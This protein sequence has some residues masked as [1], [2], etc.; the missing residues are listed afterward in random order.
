MKFVVASLV[1]FCGCV[2]AAAVMASGSLDESV[3]RARIRTERTDAE[4]AYV[5]REH[6][7]RQRFA[8]NR[9]LDEARRDRRRTLDSLRHQEGILD[10]VQ[11]KQRAAERMAA[12]RSKIAAEDSKRRE[13]A[14]REHHK[15]ATAGP[16]PAKPSLTESTPE[17]LIASE[18]PGA[19]PLSRETAEERARRA[20]DYEKRQA[21]ARAHRETVERRNAERA[22][23]GKPA[24]KA[25]PAPPSASAP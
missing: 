22:R 8:V 15:Q 17:N 2:A 6:E 3:E 24:A 9:C 16:L 14:A 23:S 11:R 10:E 4:A 7:C 13:P 25:L 21:A 20:A 19:V 12:I 18:P 5:A 1:F